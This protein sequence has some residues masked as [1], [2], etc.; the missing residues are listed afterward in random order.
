MNPTNIQDFSLLLDS[1]PMISPDIEFRIVQDRKERRSMHFL[2]HSS[3]I[4][5]ASPVFGSKF[6]ISQN[7]RTLIDVGNISPVVFDTFLRF[8]YRPLNIHISSLDF[9]SLLNLFVLATKNEV[10]SLADAINKEI[11]SR[12]IDHTNLICA[13]SALDSAPESRASQTLQSL[14]ITYL[15]DNLKTSQE[16]AQ[17]LLR[18]VSPDGQLSLPLTALLNIARKSVSFSSEV[19]EVVFQANSA[20]RAKTAKNRR[21]AEKKKRARERKYS[22]S[23][24]GSSLELVKGKCLMSLSNSRDSQG[25]MSCSSSLDDNSLEF[26]VPLI[27]SINAGPVTREDLETTLNEEIFNIEV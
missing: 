13:C 12:V 9:S 14:L 4:I 8:L 3:I 27:N 21:K 19:R 22:E 18:R 2:A 26:V 7:Q 10:S 5:D 15:V 11:H 24:I 17:V 20:V 25:D 23:D 16:L 6:S 1:E